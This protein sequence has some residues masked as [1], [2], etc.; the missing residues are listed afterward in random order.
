MSQPFN[1]SSSVI[2]SSSVVRGNIS[3]EGSLEVL[4]R[5]DG[6]ITV[7]GHVIVAESGVVQ[8]NI[9]CATLTVVGA[10]KGELRGTEAVL[11]EGGARVEGDLSAP[12][13]GIANGARVRGHVRTEDEPAFPTPRRIASPP[14]ARPAPLLA[15]PVTKVEPR[16]LPVAVP[17]PA[18]PMPF[19]V[20]AASP[21]PPPTVAVPPPARVHEMLPP[22]RPHDVAPRLR[23]HEMAPQVRA[24]EA[25]R[26]PPPPVLPSLGKGAKAKKK[27]GRDRD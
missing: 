9:A 16:P 7:S 1:A 4:G 6:D 10:V 26:R 24:P 12:R 3:G 17:A 8:G 20:A 19:V 13:V 27:K 23:A 11:I 25:E 15:K 21:A 2:G 5:V 22:P 18:A 14:A